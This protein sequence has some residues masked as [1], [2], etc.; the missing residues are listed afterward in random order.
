MT[1]EQSGQ[2]VT[3]SKHKKKKS[4]PT[5]KGLELPAEGRTQVRLNSKVLPELVTPGSVELG[6]LAKFVESWNAVDCPGSS[7]LSWGILRGIE[8]SVTELQEQLEVSHFYHLIFI[9]HTLYPS[10]RDSG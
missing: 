3:A 1:S 4:D 9:L 6:E 2:L 5:P 7:S 8:H 10:P